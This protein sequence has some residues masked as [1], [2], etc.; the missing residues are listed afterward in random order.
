MN[1]CGQFWTVTARKCSLTTIYLLAFGALVDTHQ[2]QTFIN[3]KQ[4]FQQYP[5]WCQKQKGSAKEET[6]QTISSIKYTDG[7]FRNMN[8]E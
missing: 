7:I 8:N 2:T 6:A 5:E 4:R 1:I 3:L